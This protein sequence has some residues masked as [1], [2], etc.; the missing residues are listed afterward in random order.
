[1]I[2]PI[3]EATQGRLAACH[4]VAHK[5]S[6]FDSLCAEVTARDPK[7]GRFWLALAE[8]LDDRR[9]FDDARG[10]FRQAIDAW[11]HLGEAK[12]GLGMLAMRLGQ[13]DEA[14][15]VLT[16]AFE[17]DPFN[18]R[19]ANSL[20]VLR[21]LNDYAT[22]QTPHFLVRYDAKNDAVLGRYMTEALEREYDRLSAAFQFRPAGPI[23][24]ELFN[25]HDMFSGR[26]IA[27]PDLHTIGACTGRMV[28]LVSPKGQG[29]AKP[30]NWGRVI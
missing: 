3:N 28:A 26:T 30:F 8:R 16:A 5:K 15:K 2:N 13:E 22:L 11:P 25:R 12:T 18:V 1:A 4:F 10:Y 9:L 14:R 6:E 17:A 23:L 20:K 29:V 21:H 19:I 24:I 7:P 27:L